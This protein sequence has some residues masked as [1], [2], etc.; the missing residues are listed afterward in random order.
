LFTQYA[1]AA[2]DQAIADSK[3]DFAAMSLQYSANVGVI[4]TPE[5]GGIRTFENELKRY[6]KRDGIPCFCPSLISKMIVDIAAGVTSI[7][8]KL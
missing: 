1:I 6:Y 3:I 8:H 7:R 2:T 5:N 4:W